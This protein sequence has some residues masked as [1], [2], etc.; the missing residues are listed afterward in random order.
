MTKVLIL[1]HFLKCFRLFWG[2]STLPLTFKINIRSTFREY[3][4]ECFSERLV[5]VLV[6]LRALVLVHVL[7]LVFVIM[8]VLVLVFVHWDLSRTRTWTWA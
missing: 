4:P 8:F 2:P 3:K 1:A 6:L 5:I 7:V